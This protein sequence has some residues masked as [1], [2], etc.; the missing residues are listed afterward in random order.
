ML[1]SHGT[2]KFNADSIEEC[3]YFQPNTYFFKAEPYY[4]LSIFS[5]AGFALRIHPLTEEFIDKY[6]KQDLFLRPFRKGLK[7][8]AT[9][10]ALSKIED[11]TPGI[12]YLVDV[13][14][15]TIDYHR[16]MR[17]L[18]IPGEVF[19]TEPIST[20]KVQ[21]I[22]TL[23]ENVERLRREYD[24]P[25]K[26]LTNLEIDSFF[27]RLFYTLNSRVQRLVLKQK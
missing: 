2:T 25:V 4:K 21:R 16:G 18:F 13:P 19:S 11:R 9:K 17:S 22:L 1:V 27:K 24:H 5:A 14:L 15:N 7:R 10:Y 8:I 23:E 3:G 6:C 20:K 12:I 26:P